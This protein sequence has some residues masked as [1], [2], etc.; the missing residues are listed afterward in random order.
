[1]QCSGCQQHQ[2]DVPS[3]RPIS[4][5]WYVFLGGVLP[6]EVG[7][8]LLQQCDAVEFVQEPLIYRCELVDSVHAHTAVEG[9]ER[10]THRL[11]PWLSL[12]Q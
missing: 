11:R 3:I 7:Q 2:I 4:L 9:L 5:A 10:E 12:E 8:V 6:V 1:M